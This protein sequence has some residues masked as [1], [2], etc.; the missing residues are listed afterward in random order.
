MVQKLLTAFLSC[1]PIVLLLKFQIHTEKGM[2]AKE[3]KAWGLF[4]NTF[5]QSNNNGFTIRHNNISTTNAWNKLLALLKVAHSKIKQNSEP[6][7]AIPNYTV[8]YFWGVHQLFPN[9][10]VTLD[11]LPRTRCSHISITSPWH[12]AP[13]FWNTFDPTKST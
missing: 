1:L 2:K 12:P 4:F 3:K 8:I 11:N 9:F 6:K 13:P 10:L 5:W 7:L